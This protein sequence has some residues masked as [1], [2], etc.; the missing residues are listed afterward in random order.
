MCDVIVYCA[1]FSIHYS[2]FVSYFI[3]PSSLSIDIPH[4]KEVVLMALNC[5]YCGHKSNEIKSGSG[6]SDKGKKIELRI[7]DPSDLS[8]DILKVSQWVRAIGHM[9]CCL[10]RFISELVVNH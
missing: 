4:F 3:D 10:V 2:L 6:I 8:C 5:E 9:M 7:T 1:T